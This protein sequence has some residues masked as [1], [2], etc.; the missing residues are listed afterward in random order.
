MSS[1]VVEKNDYLFCPVCMERA[2]IDSPVRT[3]IYV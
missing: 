3:D 1:A 2:Y